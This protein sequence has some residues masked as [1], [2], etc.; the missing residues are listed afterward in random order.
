MLAIVVAV[1]VVVLSTLV[2]LLATKK[3][4]KKFLDKSRQSVKLVQVDQLSHDTIRLRFALP[5]ADM[6]LGLPVGKHFK[7]F[8]PNALGIKAGE[9]N[10]RP[11]AEADSSE[12]ERK[13]TPTTSDD[14]VGIVDLV[15]KV[16]K[17]GVVDRFPDGGK[18]SQFMGALKIGDSVFLSGPWGMIEYVGRGSWVY[19]KREIQAKRVGM[20]AGGTGITPM[21]QIVAAVLKDP[22]DK[23]ELSLIFANQTEGDILVRDVLEKLAAEHP[24]R[25]KLWYTLDRPPSGWAYS[26]GF[27]DAD[28]I[29]NHLPPPDPETLILMCG[30]PPMIQYAC[31]AN[32]DKLGYK[33]AQQLAF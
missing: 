16:Y 9:W 13:Y 17:R 21:L 8:C 10:G 4:K 18:M 2:F 23:T 30:P 22:K 7:V 32:L 1:V 25:F 28:M 31:K 19:G 26:S 12:I 3:P 11:D 20:M 5:E 27:I 24:A 29:A 15:I 6:V 14:D 33:K